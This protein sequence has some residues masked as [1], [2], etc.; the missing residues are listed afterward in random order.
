[1]SANDS[2]K[3]R[4]FRSGDDTQ[5]EILPVELK[6]EYLHEPLGLETLH[7]RFSWLLES[8]MRG[9][10]QSAYQILVVSSMDK[11]PTPDKWDS[12]RIASDQSVGI[13]Y[14]GSALASGERC[15]WKVRVW[16]KQGNAGA[17]SSP[18]FFEMGLMNR[19]DWAGRWIGAAKGISSPL[20]RKEF[21]INGVVRRAR[22]YIAGLG[23]YELYLNGARVGDH[24]LDPASTY[25][26]NDQPSPLHSR[27]LYVVYDV[28]GYLKPGL[29]SVGVMLGNGWYSAEAD[30]SPSA[31]VPYAD[32][33]RLLAQ[34]NIEFPD[35]KTKII[36][37]DET[38]KVSSG[39]I[40]YN[41]LGNGETYDAR[42]EQPGW[43]RP[44]FDDSRWNK[45]VL[46]EP[47]SGTLVAQLIP[48]A[49]V[50]R[51]LPPVRALKAKEAEM[52]MTVYVYDFGQTFSGWVRIRVS[53]PRGTPITLK[54]GT[55]IY[56]EDNTL[57]NRSNMGPV[58]PA[59]Q[60][61]TYILKG[62][63][64]EEWE[65]R[66]TLHGFRYVEVWGFRETPSLDG[67]EGRFVRSSVEPQGTF[68]SSNDLIN[69]IHHNIQWAF[70]SSF[71]G[72]PQDAAD[73]YERVAWLGDPGFVADDYVYNYDVSSFWEKWLN[74]IKDAQKPDGDL[75]VVAP[76]HWREGVYAMWPDW[77]STYPL[78]LWDLY[79]FYDDKQ[80]LRDH[81]DSLKKFV[82]FLSRN[83]KNYIISAGLGDHMEPQ[84]TGFSH[85]S[86]L[87]TPG[88]LVETA[89][90]YYDTWILCQAAGI[91]GQS[92]DEKKY[93]ELADSIRHAFN[94]DFFN[95]ATS[96]YGTGSQTSNAL[97]LYLR[98]VPE[99]RVSAVVKNLVDDIERKHNWHQSTGIVG[100]NA[101]AQ[102][103][104]Q[105]G[106]ADAMYRILTQTTYPSLGY[107]V[108]K[109]AT[110][111][112]EV[113][114]DAPWLSQDMKMFGSVEKFFYRNL[115]GIG[116][117]SPG[118]RE[119][120]I[121]PQI[122]GD[123]TRASASLQTVRGTVSVKW[124]KSD[125]AFEL[126]TSVPTN[127]QSHVS[128]PKLGLENVMI[129]EDGKPVWQN[130]SYVPG[131]EGVTAG[132][133]S[134]D[135]VT[136]QVGSGAYDF[137][138]ERHAK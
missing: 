114:E 132:V 38:W 133:E 62:G 51:T 118:F 121:K 77:K 34:M 113:M 83:S 44:G 57:D 129:T 36:A 23:Y 18:S 67:I 126:L 6:T 24:V 127:A 122:V 37:T 88:P 84:E 93:S 106:A 138:F 82:E 42:L 28:T 105:H 60:T 58:Q 13:S 52:F 26:N 101:L 7:P 39:P 1:V 107:Q 61:D 68:S 90:Y 9:Q 72:I 81:Y 2:V 33:P 74:D 120:V 27:V 104:P 79:R 89:Y 46:L 29:N 98:M 8:G 63:G 135:Y 66:F 97:P 95:K 80:V 94:D 119:I 117:G 116:L 96:Q 123:L 78:L 103:L 20:L 56:S 30:V 21:S 76:L 86:P 22:V 73:R 11:L 109:G 45:A 54:Y 32:R 35:G 71:Q 12:G 59:R 91:L 31:R 16:D 110:A 134:Q 108:T 10:M 50:V 75:P 49:R 102:A 85:F 43:D 100:T 40:T 130:H 111:L 131:V 115:A 5:T 15:Y 125:N 99:D 41:D 3:P 14:Q 55:R 87:H 25:Y 124:Q 112:W 70:M 4:S 17:Y 48:P 64:P 69:Q 92:D 47:P 136:F 137:K 19:S 65:P 53:G 128:V